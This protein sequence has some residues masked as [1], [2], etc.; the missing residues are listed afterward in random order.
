MTDPGVP[1]L[2]TSEW[3]DAARTARSLRGL[4]RI[5]GHGEVQGWARTVRA[6]PGDAHGVHEAVQRAVAGDVLVIDFGGPETRR[7]GF[8]EL[9]AGEAIRRGAVGVVFWGPV[10]DVGRLT[11]LGL[12]VVATGTDPM[13]GSHAVPGEH[14]VDVIIAGERVRPGDL[15]AIDDDGVLVVD[16]GEALAAGARA[17]SMRE[18]DRAIAL[19]IAAGSP[20]TEH[21]S[22]RAYLD[23]VDAVDGAT[24]PRPSA[25]SAPP[26]EAD[27]GC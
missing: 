4:R 24:D 19:A 2:S 20:L 22:Y 10:R 8:G 14:D 11:R 3:A 26:G 15:I 16:R 27:P 18:H 12:T 6:E 7:A 9:V 13:P 1:S 23:A 21:P 17:I 5:A 25:D